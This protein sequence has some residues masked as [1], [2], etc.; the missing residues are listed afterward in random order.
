M[1]RIAPFKWVVCIFLE[2]RM[3]EKGWKRGLGLGFPRH[4]LVGETLLARW[5]ITNID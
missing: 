1:V 4:N 2:G 3:G 5:Q